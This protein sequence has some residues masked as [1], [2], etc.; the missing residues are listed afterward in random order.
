MKS[1]KNKSE[2]A[3]LRKKKHIRKVVFG[4]PEKPRLVVFK[5]LKHIYAQLVDD[6]QQRTITGVSSL[7]GELKEAVSKAKN[8]MEV[9]KIVGLGIA[10][11][12]KELN[13]EQVVFDRNGYIY[14][15]RVKAVADAAREGGLK[16]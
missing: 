7:T 6:T 11:K 14:H 2:L 15:G 10:K 3:R 4:T 12:A 9:S 13:V 1:K 5:S 8:R 16:F